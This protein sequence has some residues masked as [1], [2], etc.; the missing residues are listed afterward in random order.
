MCR[1][2]GRRERRATEEGAAGRQ[3]TAAV[4]RARNKAIYHFVS[5][6][7]PACAICRA[8]TPHTYVLLLLPV[9]CEMYDI[10][11]DL[12]IG[13]LATSNIVG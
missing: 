5:Y 9:S 1:P 3:N 2:S 10:W 6:L 8:K 13:V 11:N 12:E 4:M 7:L